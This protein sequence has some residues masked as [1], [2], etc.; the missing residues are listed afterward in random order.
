MP[1]RILT[2]ALLIA[3]G[4]IA[5]GSTS[6]LAQDAVRARAVVNL[7]FDE[8]TGDALDSAAAGQAADNGQ[9]AG[10]A[11][12]V[13]S[14]FWN[15]SGK[16]AVLFDAARVQHVLVPDSADLDRPEALSLAF[17]F[18]NL[19]ASDDTAARGVVAKRGAAGPSASNYGI[20]YVVK[21]DIFQLYVNDGSGFKVVQYSAKAV[22]G[23]RRLNHLTA[24]FAVGD[25][26]APDADEDRDDIHVRLYLNG[27]VQQPQNVAGGRVID[28]EAWLTDVKL[29]G[30]LNDVPL[31]LG[32]TNATQEPASCLIDE[33]ALFAEA[34]SAEDVSRLFVEVAGPHAEEL[35]RR[36]LQPPSGLPPA[37][38]IDVLSRH[39]LQLGQPNRLVIRG[40][41]LAPDPAVILGESRLAQKF[42]ED[43]NTGQATV[44]LMLPDDFPAGFYPLRVQTPAGLSNPLVVAVD[45]LPQL[46]AAETSAEKPAVLPGAFGGELSGAAQPRVYFQGSKGQRIVAEVE[47]RRLGGAA[48]PVLEFKTWRGTPLDLNWGELYLRRDPRCIVVLPA[49]GIYFAELHDLAYQ[50][51]GRNPFRIKLGELTLYDAFLPPA[52]VPGSPVELEPIGPGADSGRKI[53]VEIPAQGL[54]S[55]VLPRLPA[56]RRPH[57]PVPAIQ[58]SDAAEFVE[59]PADADSPQTIDAAFPAGHHAGIVISGRISARGESDRYRLD[60][61]PGQSLTFALT[62]R[63]MNSPID[64]QVSILVDGRVQLTREEVQQLRDPVFNYQVPAQTRQIEVSVADFYGRGG[65]NYLYR[66]H[67]APANRPGLSLTVDAAQISLPENG[68]AV[69]SLQLAR[70]GYGGP[71]QL[72]ADGAP[73]VQIVPDQIPAGSGDRRFFARLSHSG[74]VDG[75]RFRTLRLVAESVGLDPLVRTTASVSAAPG[76][77]LPPAFEDALAL[78]VTAPAPV[79]FELAAVPPALFKGAFSELPL[80]FTWTSTETAGVVR[81]SLRS[82]EAVRPVNPSDPNQGTKP[83]VAAAPDQIAFVG[84]AS[85]TLRID[86]PLDVAEAEIEFVAVAELVPHAYSDRVLGVAYS[87]PFRLAVLPAVTVDLAAETFQLKADAPNILR[88]SVKRTAGFDRPVEVALAGLPQGYA[89][90]RITVA[91]EQS[92]FEL[93]ITAGQEEKPRD[94]PNIKLQVTVAGGGAILPER[95]LPLK[96]AP[97]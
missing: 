62:G 30:L 97:Q 36:E 63:G 93:T 92:D 25:A 24:T 53:P 61:T 33:F 84:A 39:G 13:A 64:A 38:Q 10:G 60:V 3:L 32:A 16:R 51:P 15:Q 59:T 27:L 66:L 22:I 91:P 5:P 68:T 70:R 42:A 58:L 94:L 2:G 95:D 8:Q 35:V 79:A 71:V 78:A 48:D 17:F 31:T 41:N 21:N 85:G 77:Q 80:A 96:V 75:E 40:R 28:G 52:V 86:V 11:A 18:L 72:R 50:A 81:L 19:H 37:P 44:E 88:G 34:L 23:V 47:C 12:R 6:L 54:R 4:L 65:P 45:R 57:G 89:A 9:L 26:P 73:D 56:D 46:M 55:A 90:P 74:P 87:R 82:T 49:D 7:T 43:S 69:V 76:T 29:D 1:T 67:V 14:P 83:L 20:N